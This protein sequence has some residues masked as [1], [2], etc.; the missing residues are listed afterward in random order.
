MDLKGKLVVAQGGGPTA[1]INQSMVGVAL[2]ARRYPQ[3]T[4]VYGALNGINGIV[5]E[6][7]IDL[8]QETTEN[9]ELVA[10]TPSSGL[11][12]TRDKPDAKYCEEIFRVFKAHDVRY[13]FYIGG[14]DSSDTVRIVNEYA[15]KSNYDFR[16]IHV[17]KTIDNDL[18][19]NDHTPGFP[20]AARF[21][22]QAFM[23]INLDNRALP[24]VHISVIMGRHAGYLT[25]ASSAA[26]RFS[27][28]GPHL[29]YVPERAFSIDKFLKD[30]KS[31]YD[32][33]GRC[34]VAVSEGIQ[35]ANG[36]PVLASLMDLATDDHGNVQLSGTGALG[37][38]LANEVK[39][40][41]KIGRVRSDTFGYL[42]RSF[43]GCVSD[44]DQRE[45]REVGE[46][47]VQFAMNGATEGSVTI[48]R[49]GNY[50]VDYKLNPIEDI[51]AKTKLMPD[52]FI[53]A[54]G[55]HVTPAF[56]DYLRP[57]LGSNMP[58]AARLRAP[59]AEKL[60]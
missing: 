6:N 23:G 12:S 58:E 18:M 1:V 4:H 5:N 14:N 32:R 50:A 56:E 2:E 27:D 28:D 24:G 60:N 7:F 36:T 29:I 57:L 53:N 10:A 17:P 39:D 9:L 35:D 22:A 40:K 30:V 47:A 44:V 48:N 19:C 49:V 21:V 46:R 11:G 26:R 34:I 25:A 16:A 38:L 20:S 51:A 37:E 52:E 3:I 59:R 13:F 8:S 33:L 45:A 42:Q 31:V 15:K 54:E 55:N 41:L 43:M